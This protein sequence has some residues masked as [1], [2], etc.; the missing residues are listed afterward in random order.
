VQ[1]SEIWWI[2]TFVIRK[3]HYYRYRITGRNDLNGGADIH[4]AIPDLRPAGGRY[5]FSLRPV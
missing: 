2:D 3:G 1:L 5:A 4:W